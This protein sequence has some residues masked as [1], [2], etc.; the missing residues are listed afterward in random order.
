MLIEG[1]YI[2]RFH[3]IISVQLF[4]YLAAQLMLDLFIYLLYTRLVILM[5]SVLP[6]ITINLKYAN[7]KFI[8]W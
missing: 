1:I 4:L 3:V 7:L 8:A 5:Y 6:N 2:F